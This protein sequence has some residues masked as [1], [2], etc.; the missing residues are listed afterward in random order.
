MYRNQ[1]RIGHFEEK[2]VKFYTDYLVKGQIP[3]RIRYNYAGSD[4]AKKFRIRP[5]P[6]PLKNR[7]QGTT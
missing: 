1:R 6:D 5:E 2:F 7:V 3:I 4:L